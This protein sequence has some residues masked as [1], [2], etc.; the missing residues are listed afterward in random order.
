VR[1]GDPVRLVGRDRAEAHGE[2]L[3]RSSPGDA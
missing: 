2:S 3:A 1:P